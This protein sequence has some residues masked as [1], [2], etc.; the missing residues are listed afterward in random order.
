MPASAVS[1]LN[2]WGVYVI[3]SAALVLVLSPILIGTANDSREGVDWRNV[4]AIGTA[5]DELRPGVTLEISFGSSSSGDVVQLAGHQVSCS[6]GGGTV[7]MS[8]RWTL[9]E[10]TLSPSV[11]YSV[12]LNGGNVRVA[13]VG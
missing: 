11:H 10:V 12:W 5:M 1:A 9:P 2:S 13:Q 7:S 3:A 8:S 4:D 6:Y